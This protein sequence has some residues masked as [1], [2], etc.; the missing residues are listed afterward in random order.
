MGGAVR[1]L[2]R[3]PRIFPS[4]TRSSQQVTV[5]RVEGLDPHLRRSIRTTIPSDSSPGNQRARRAH[6]TRR[7]DVGKKFSR[8][9]FRFPDFSVQAI[10]LSILLLPP[11]RFLGV[12]ET[13]IFEGGFFFQLT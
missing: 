3:L 12:S 8:L 13:G 5:L 9:P 6:A 4:I 1:L 2:K 7:R 10:T 11:V